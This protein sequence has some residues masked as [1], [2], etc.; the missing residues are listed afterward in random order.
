MLKLLQTSSNR[1]TLVAAA[2]F[3]YNIQKM[4]LLEIFG[5]AVIVITS[6]YLYFSI[7]F[8]Y[9]KNVGVPFAQPTFPRGSLKGVGVKLH[10]SEAID[11]SYKEFKDKS[12]FFG[13]YFMINPVAFITDL[14]LIK[15]VLVKDSHNFLNKGNFYNEKDDP[16]SAHLF[17][18]DNPKWKSLRTKLTPTF[19]SGKMKMMF[20][21]IVDV[22]NK[23]AETMDK[24]TKNVQEYEIKD[25]MARFTT[26]VIGSCAFGLDISSL[27]DPQSEFREMGKKTFDL[28]LSIK[29]I[30]MFNFK[31]L[32]TKLGMKFI[33]EDVAAFFM[34]VVIDTV[35]YREREKIIRPDFM[36]LL[37]QMKNEGT[38]DSDTEP[39]KKIVTG[40]VTIEEVA[41]QA[42][43]FFLGN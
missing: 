8:N 40:K 10:R 11:K 21:T 16:L 3:A 20:G 35:E 19:T 25:I 24:E 17:N 7:K 6:I 26:D 2:T 12:P 4:V 14:D 33:L 27:E 23:F 43:V 37:I 39:G 22:A 41:A 34:K 36:N 38:I 30:F 13:M 9:W 31:N 1:L 15:A 28:A 18:I 29:T 5:F 42:F 32:A